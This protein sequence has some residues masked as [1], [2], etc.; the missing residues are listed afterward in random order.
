MSKGPGSYT[1]IRIALTIAKTIVFALNIPLYL[2]SSLQVMKVGD[3][4]TICLTNARSQRSYIGVYQG[5]KEILSDRIMKQPFEV[6]ASAITILGD[7]DPDYPLQK[8]FHTM[9]YLRDI[10]YLRPRTNTF[11][12]L[13]RVRSV[14]AM[15][16]HE[17]FQGKGFI[18]VH[19][20][21]ITAND[22]E[23]AG[24]V[25]TVTTDAKDP[26]ND[27]YGRRAS[28]T[29]SGQ[30]HEE[31]TQGR[32]AQGIGEHRRRNDIDH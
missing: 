16:I 6:H 17:F 23:G 3:K 1:G 19:T 31:M 7:V 8:K 11:T 12:A 30:L 27:F 20:P 18:Y 28:L 15:A 14:L 5:Q 26:I 25:F 29:V 24:Q 22:A 10:A 13:Y 32:L 2:V 9:E 21:E 4:P